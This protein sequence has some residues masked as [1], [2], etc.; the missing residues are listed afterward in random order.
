M[1]YTKRANIQSCKAN[2]KGYIYAL[3]D[4]DEPSKWDMISYDD[5]KEAH[6]KENVRYIGV[7]S[8]P[9]E[10]FCD[11]RCDKTKSKQI[12]MVIFDEAKHPA[13]GKAKEGTA[14]WQYIQK[15]GKGPKYQKG[16]DTWA[17]A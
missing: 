7:T 16:D 4:L 17:G 13:E 5:N 12:G 9:V 8:N 14:I 1:N 2:D 15:Y 11:H 10:R 3:V 6:L